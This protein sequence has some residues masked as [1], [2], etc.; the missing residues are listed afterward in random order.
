MHVLDFA[1]D[2]AERGAVQDPRHANERHEIRDDD[3]RPRSELIAAINRPDRLDLRT[4]AT[5]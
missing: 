5:L 3:D 4:Q 1:P 2:M